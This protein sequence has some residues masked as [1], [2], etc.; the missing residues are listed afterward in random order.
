MPDDKRI[1]ELNEATE[2]TD[3]HYLAV[4]VENGETNKFKTSDFLGATTPYHFVYGVLCCRVLEE[5]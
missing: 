1:I 5:E 4:D 2:L 3:N